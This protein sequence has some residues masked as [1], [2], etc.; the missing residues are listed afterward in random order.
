M[1]VA[2]CDGCPALCCRDLNVWIAAPK[3][4][5]EI[6]DLLWQIQFDTVRIYIRNRRWYLLVKGNCMYLDEDNR[7]T[8][9][10]SRPDKC[11]KHLPP[12]CERYG[13]FWDIMFNTP[14][15]LKAYIEKRKRSAKKRARERAGRGA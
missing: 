5:E 13:E 8:I 3:T 14:Q 12:E 7:C 10:E 2:A 1:Q 11:R 4:N 15:E 6:D 9:Y